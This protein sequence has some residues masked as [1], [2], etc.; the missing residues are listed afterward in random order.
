MYYAGELSDDELEE[1]ELKDDDDDDDEE[2]G[3]LIG[4]SN[5]IELE[6]QQQQQ[7]QQQKK[8]ELNEPTNQLKR[9]NQTQQNVCRFYSKGNVSFC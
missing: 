2:E 7:Q 4:D 1:G 5:N 9:P 3:N 6:Q 8:V